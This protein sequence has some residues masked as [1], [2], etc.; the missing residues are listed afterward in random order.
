M[1]RSIIFILV[2]ITVFMISCSS[3]TS[4]DYPFEITAITPENGATNVNRAT[5]IAVSF[6]NNLNWASVV[7]GASFDVWDI[8]NNVQVNGSITAVTQN[9][10][11]FQPSATL[12]ANSLHE[13]YISADIEDV[14]GN[15]YYQDYTSTFTTG[16]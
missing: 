9:T 7:W 16:S 6:T 15:F 14:W 8:T 11:F 10:I 4:D 3:N 2:I 13:V 12:N 5:G 1:K